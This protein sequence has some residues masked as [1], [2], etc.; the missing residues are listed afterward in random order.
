MQFTINNIE[1]NLTSKDD[2]VFATS[3][4]V[5]KVFK[6]EHDKVV[7][8]IG[9]LIQKD[10]A[11]IGG[12]FFKTVYFDTYSRNQRA[13][14]MTRDGFSLLVMGFTGEKAINWKL[15]FIEAFNKMETMIQIPQHQVPLT[16]PEALRAYADA[17]EQK[18][19]ALLQ[20]EAEAPR[21]AFAQRLQKCEGTL[22]IRDYAK[23]LCDKG[24]PLGEKRLFERL[25]NLGILMRDNK[26]Y[27]HY[28]DN[29]VLAV[30]EGIYINSTTGDDVAYM[31]VRV[32]AKGQEYI[33]N[34]LTGA[35]K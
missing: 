1:V 16:L 6:K 31:Q 19:K 7:R 20:L 32:T 23:L 15:D 27:Q 12:M 35:I 11:K 3:I 13:Y 34:K 5:A 8:D 33:Y 28:I 29:G 4:D 9:K 18:Q 14:E 26:P 10:V 17:E 22:S 24:L 30:K 21:V 25:R 2:K